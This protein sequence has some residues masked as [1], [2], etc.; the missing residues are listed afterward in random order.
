M[1]LGS[2]QIFIPLTRSPKAKRMAAYSSPRYYGFIHMTEG[3]YTLVDMYWFNGSLVL[4]NYTRL[5]FAVMH[6]ND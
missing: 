2:T 4:L 1:K 5:S 3:I 6:L